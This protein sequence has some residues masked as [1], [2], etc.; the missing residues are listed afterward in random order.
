MNGHVHE[1]PTMHYFGN[2]GHTESMTEYMIL[3]EYALLALYQCISIIHL[4]ADNELYNTFFYSNQLNDVKKGG[5]TVFPE[6]GV[7]VWPEKVCIQV[8]VW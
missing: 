7:T 8:H 4:L 2:P 1:Y 5:A 6:L 3:T